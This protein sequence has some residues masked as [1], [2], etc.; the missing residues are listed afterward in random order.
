MYD[1]KFLVL[2]IVFRLERER[3]K[4]GGN[5]SNPKTYLLRSNSEIQIVLTQNINIH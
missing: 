4:S 5:F 1:V 3:E 2:I